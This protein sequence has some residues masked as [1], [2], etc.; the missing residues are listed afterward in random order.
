MAL[1]RIKELREH[2]KLCTFHWH[3]ICLISQ[4]PVHL[5]DARK[6]RLWIRNPVWWGLINE[7]VIEF[8]ASPGRRVYVL[9]C[10]LSEDL[11][12][13][14]AAERSYPQWA[15]QFMTE[16]DLFHKR[17]IDIV[18]G[19]PSASFALLLDIVGPH[20]FYAPETPVRHGSAVE[21]T[22]R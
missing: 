6:Y 15:R 2:Y 4:E 10:G 9:R 12:L 3:E 1:E 19:S 13:I 22:S 20:I 17:C 14:T 16:G 5:P 18:R 7:E 8:H 21:S 11:D